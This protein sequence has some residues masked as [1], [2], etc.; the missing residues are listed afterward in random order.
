MPSAVDK[1][2]FADIKNPNKEL[3]KQHID[4]Y[5]VIIAKAPEAA[6]LKAVDPKT[7]VT[8]SSFMVKFIV[9]IAGLICFRIDTLLVSSHT[10]DLLILNVILIFH[11]V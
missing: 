7:V 10:S 1:E 2:F 9:K 8:G 4:T 11:R 3:K 5:M 6:G